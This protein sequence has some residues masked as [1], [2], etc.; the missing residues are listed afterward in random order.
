MDLGEGAPISKVGQ[1]PRNPVLPV[2]I[3][4]RLLLHRRPSQLSER[5]GE[6]R[7]NIPEIVLISAHPVLT[8]AYA[9]STDGSSGSTV[10]CV[11]LG[12][13]LVKDILD[14]GKIRFEDT[15]DEKRSELFQLR[16][17]KISHTGF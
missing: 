8:C 16:K 7:C 12:S 13:S 15:G 4:R 10:T 14:G 9:A 2:A 11:G 1:R 6:K 3:G 17:T 5:E